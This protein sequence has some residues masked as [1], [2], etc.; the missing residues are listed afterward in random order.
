MLRGEGSNVST[1]SRGRNGGLESS[2]VYSPRISGYL[3]LTAVQYVQCVHR[4]GL[5]AWRCAFEVYS[6][7]TRLR[8]FSTTLCIYCAVPALLQ[9][10]FRIYREATRHRPACEAGVRGHKI[11]D[12]LRM[13]QLATTQTPMSCRPA[14]RKAKNFPRPSV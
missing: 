12:I 6:R 8:L 7:C 14:G 2:G 10:A 4:L 13:R 11:P 9:A 3:D 1:T 5:G